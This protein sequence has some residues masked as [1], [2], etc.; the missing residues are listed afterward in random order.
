MSCAA[1]PKPDTCSKIAAFGST[2]SNSARLSSKVTVY[3]R[4]D[5]TTSSELRFHSV[6]SLCA[7]GWTRG[8]KHQEI[9]LLRAAL[10]RAGGLCVKCTSLLQALFTHGAIKAL[11]HITMV[12]QSEF[13]KLLCGL[14]AR[15]A[16]K[17]DPKRLANKMRQKETP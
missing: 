13:A 4:W 3:R 2:D 11:D 16:A 15:Q 10:G 8:P 5:F 12:R 6:W 14:R 9:S 7:K 1:I 17:V